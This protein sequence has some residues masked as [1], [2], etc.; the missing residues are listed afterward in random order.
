MPEFKAGVNCGTVTVAQ[1][2]VEKQEIAYLSDV[3]NTAARI[4]GQCNQHGQRLL[5]SDDVRR[6]VSNGGNFSFEQL[7]AISLRGKNQ[8]VAIFG[9]TEN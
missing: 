3:L 9:V 8:E 6:L 1:V 4:E 2:G 5:V 7:G